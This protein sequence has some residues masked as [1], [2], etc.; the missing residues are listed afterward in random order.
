MLLHILGFILLAIVIFYL[1]VLYFK[2]PHK[3]GFGFKTTAEE[4]MK[5]INM[6]GKVVIITGSNTGLGYE[7]AR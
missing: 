7:N 3:N 2:S 4:I 1:F 6:E 5:D